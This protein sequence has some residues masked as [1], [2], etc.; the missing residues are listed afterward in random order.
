[1][2]AWAGG[3]LGYSAFSALP[4]PPDRDGGAPPQTCVDVV[5]LQAVSKMRHCIPTNPLAHTPAHAHAY[6]DVQAKLPTFSAPI[7]RRG[8][9]SLLR[10]QARE[11]IR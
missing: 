1:M 4:L 3:Q 9:A 7:A 10:A 11:N 5:S 8:G 6:L 2:R